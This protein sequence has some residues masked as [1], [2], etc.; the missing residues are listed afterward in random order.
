MFSFGGNRLIRFSGAENS[1]HL[2][3]CLRA[4]APPGG[5][6][7]THSCN[8]RSKGRNYR[9]LGHSHSTYSILNAVL[10]YFI[11][12]SRNHTAVLAP[13]EAILRAEE[14]SVILKAYVLVTSLRPLRAF[15]H[16]TGTVWSPPKKKRFTVKVK[17]D[18][19]C[20]FT[21]YPKRSKMGRA[22]ILWPVWL[23]NPLEQRLPLFY[24]CKQR[25]PF[26][27]WKIKNKLEIA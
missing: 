5:E 1:T 27:T 19:S 14:L 21:Q 15:I 4:R 7:V 6:R 10:C 13:R 24:C 16:S 20:Y 8:L 23:S 11:F 3:A 9:A 22:A 18:W 12:F 17:S 25:F 26:N 2:V